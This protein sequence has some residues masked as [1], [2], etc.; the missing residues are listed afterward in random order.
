MEIVVTG[1]VKFDKED[2]IRD[3]LTACIEEIKDIPRFHV[4]DSDRL[5]D[6]IVKRYCIEFGVPLEAIER[7][8]TGDPYR[9]WDVPAE[10]ALLLKHADLLLAFP[11]GAGTT[12]CCTQAH[13]MDV[14][15][16]EFTIDLWEQWRVDARYRKYKL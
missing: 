4:R 1:G 16:L 7:M 15:I 5:P 6:S 13:A 11:G 3:C 8:T 9:I 14:P 2:F 10:N 12:D